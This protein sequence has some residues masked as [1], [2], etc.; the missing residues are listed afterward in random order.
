MAFLEKTEMTLCGPGRRN[1]FL[2]LTPKDC[3]RNGYSPL[4]SGYAYVSKVSVR[5]KKDDSHQCG[6]GSVK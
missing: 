2:D 1:G 6:D 4:D 5:K 3:T